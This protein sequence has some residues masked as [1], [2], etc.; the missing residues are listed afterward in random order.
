MTKHLLALLCVSALGLPI[1][2]VP[3]CGQAFYGS[4][5]GTVT[6]QSGAAVSGAVVRLINTGTQERH[7]GPTGAD[8]S[9]QFLNIFIG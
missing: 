8:G 3:L 9:Y 7:Q 1:I 6:D 2:T 5:V 4:V